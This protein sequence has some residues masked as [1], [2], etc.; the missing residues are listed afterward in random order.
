M[1]EGWAEDEPEISSVG[2]REKVVRARGG[3][4]YRWEFKFLVLVWPIST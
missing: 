4:F 1:H 3:L 2:S